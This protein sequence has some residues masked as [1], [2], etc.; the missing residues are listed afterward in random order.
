[1]TPSVTTRVLAPQMVHATVALTATEAIIVRSTSVLVK[2][3]LVLDT[4]RVIL[5][6]MFVRVILAGLESAAIS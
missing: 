4:V 6:L 1:M 5:P 2:G 3:S